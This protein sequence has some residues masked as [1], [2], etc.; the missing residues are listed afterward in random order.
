MFALGEPNSI[1]SIRP[2]MFSNFHSLDTFQRPVLEKYI[3]EA[4]G[5][6]MFRYTYVGTMY[7]DR[8]I[9]MCGLTYLLI[10]HG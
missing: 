4:K 8:L 2:N 6:L 5:L 10:L 7:L 9:C 1:L 3:Y